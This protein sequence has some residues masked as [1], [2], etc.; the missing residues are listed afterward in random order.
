[1]LLIVIISIVVLSVFLAFVSLW[2]QNSIA[3]VKETKKELEKEKV[4]F[5]SDSS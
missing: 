2:R 3:E 1:M 5:Y 4:V